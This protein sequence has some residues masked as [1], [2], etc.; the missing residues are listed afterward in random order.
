[1]A[2]PSAALVRRYFGRQTEI[3]DDLPD[4]VSPLSCAR[5]EQAFGY[6]PAY[7]WTETERHPEGT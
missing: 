5:A 6:R 1:L 4:D 2:E 3:R 7:I